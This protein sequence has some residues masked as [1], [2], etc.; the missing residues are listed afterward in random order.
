MDN[1]SEQKPL[2]DTILTHTSSVMFLAPHFSPMCCTHEQFIELYDQVVSSI[3]CDIDTVVFVLLSKFEVSNWLSQ[4]QQPS[5]MSVANF[6]SRTM[7]AVGLIGREPNTEG[8]VI[9]EIIR[10]HMNT[11]LRSDLNTQ[12][13][14]VLTELLSLSFGGTVSVFCWGDF[15]SVLEF[16][17][18]L[19]PEK[20]C[21]ISI[22][23]VKESLHY[24]ASYFMNVCESLNCELEALYKT[25]EP[26]IE[27]LAILLKNLFS[28]SIAH[29]LYHRGERPK[30]VVL[31]DQWELIVSVFRPWIIPRLA[32]KV[33]TLLRVE[34]VIQLVESFVGTIHML[35]TSSLQENENSYCYVLNDLLTFYAS[36]ITTCVREDQSVEIFHAS[37]S[38]L[39]WQHLC[40]TLQ[41]MAFVLQVIMS[42][43]PNYIN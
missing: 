18:D 34:N 35:I 20:E 10:N 11:L 8:L 9:L 21:R 33:W 2:L 26:Y 5:Q 3:L 32:G 17:E 16:G 43:Q 24:M 37:L 7:K 23:R 6:L 29:S 13:W 38:T 28:Y 40:P 41:E 39:P 4:Q 12:Y 1:P 19:H 42:P 30:E 31:R 14:L 36:E 22:D 15:L 25:W 27:H